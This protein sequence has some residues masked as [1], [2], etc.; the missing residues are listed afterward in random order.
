MYFKSFKPTVLIA[1]SS[2]LPTLPKKV[3]SQAMVWFT[4]TSFVT[5]YNFLFIVYLRPFQFC[6]SFILMDFPQKFMFFAIKNNHLLFIINSYRRIFE[7]PF[8]WN[9]HYPT[10]KYMFVEYSWNITIIY[11]LNI[12]KKF[13]MK[14]RGIFAN[15]VPGIWNIRI[16]P[17]CSMNIL[18]MLHAYFLVDQEI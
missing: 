6:S 4:F 12:W 11:S 7:Q 8:S 1:N 2:N 5:S 3:L 15:N 14:F 13:P 9:C 10:G 17:K 18:R 16:F